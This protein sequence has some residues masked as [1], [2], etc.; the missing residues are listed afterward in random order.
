MIE[1]IQKI[2]QGMRKQ[3]YYLEGLAQANAVLTRSNSAVMAKLAQMN[4]TM[5]AMQVQLKAL[6]SAK[7]NQARP[8]RKHYFWSCRRNILTGSKPAHQRKRHTKRKLNTRKGW[9]EVKR[10]ANDG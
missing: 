10:D 6:S 9:V 7:N 1:E 8:K 4:V 3:D 5:K 2:V